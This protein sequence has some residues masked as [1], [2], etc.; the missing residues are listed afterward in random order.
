MNDTD[1]RLIKTYKLHN[2]SAQ[3]ELK[4]ELHNQHKA[5][6]WQEEHLWA[7]ALDLSIGRNRIRLV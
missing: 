4:I 5:L 3:V 1:I 6:Y 7:K 2:K